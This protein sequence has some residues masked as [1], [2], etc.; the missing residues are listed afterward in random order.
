VE[1]KGFGIVRE[2]VTLAHPTGIRTWG[3]FGFKFYLWRFAFLNYTKLTKY[4]A[5]EKN[6]V[7][8]HK[9]PGSALSSTVR[10]LERPNFIEGFAAVPPMEKADD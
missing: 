10:F 8:R 9:S 6:A 7:S 2:P 1:L 4:E 3:E 5:L